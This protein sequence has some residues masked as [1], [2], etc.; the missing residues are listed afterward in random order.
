MTAF[1]SLSDADLENLLLY[2]N[3]MYDFGCATGD[4][5]VAA[6]ATEGGAAVEEQSNTPFFIVLSIFLLILV[7]VLGRI[8][9]NV[10]RIDA[11][12]AGLEAEKPSLLKLI[13]SKQL[14]AV[15]VFSLVV[16]GGYL[17]V[18]G[19]INL[20]RQ[21]GYQPEQPIEFSHK[22]H[23]GVNEIPCEFC[24]DGARR[25]K[26]SVI[27][28]TSTCMSCHK[29]IKYRNEYE[30]ISGKKLE[31]KKEIAKIY[32]SAGYDPTKGDYVDVTKYSADAVKVLFASYLMEDKIKANPA[33]I[34]EDSTSLYNQIGE[35]YLNELVGM[36]GKSIEWKRIHNL[37]DHVYFSH[38]QHVTVGKI[39]CQD[40]HGPIEDM[41]VVEQHA[42]LSMGWCINCHRETEV[43]FG[44]NDYYN[45]DNYTEY[46]DELVK[47]ERKNVTVEDIGGLECQKCHY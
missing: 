25:S 38:E 18:N 2:I 8:I 43:Q 47:G 37:P 42:P 16:I 1:E 5:E 13:F 9:Q 36:F 41:E 31:S 44:K 40:C 15:A 35:N 23:A 10:K 30:E 14:L 7:L 28:A 46:H 11:V 24:H 45:S 32:A 17:T 21:Q 4:C 26:H 29:A 12:E 34:K 20:N 27:P 22:L 3:N 39:E 6:V 33:L 19:A